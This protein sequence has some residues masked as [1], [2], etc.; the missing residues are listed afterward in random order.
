MRPFAG[1]EGIANNNICSNVKSNRFFR[2]FDIGHNDL[3]L[4][5]ATELAGPYGSVVCAMFSFD[6]ILKNINT[7]NMIRKDK[8][9]RS[10][11]HS[12]MNELKKH[13]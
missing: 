13:Q 7:V 4:C 10:L 2:E 12:Y 8:E 1:G 11:V 6:H 3:L 9:F 5:L